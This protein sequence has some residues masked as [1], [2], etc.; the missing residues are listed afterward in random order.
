M[1]RCRRAFPPL[2]LLIFL[3]LPLALTGGVAGAF[4]GGGVISL[5]SLVGFVTVL[6]IAVRNGIMLV[7]HYRHLV[8][9]EGEDRRGA[10]VR[11]SRERLVP[12]L[13]TAL[14][15]GLALVP[16]AL[17][18]GEPGNEIQ[19]P[20]ALVILGGLVS[21]TALCMVTLPV[22]YDRFGRAGGVA[23]RG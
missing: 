2:V 14:G 16:I 20:M 6:G 10:I 3:T 9:V 18:M 23:E 8:E 1:R 17:A 4:L 22:L 12:I 21:S 15:T 5:G 7:S 11:G 19:A 13:M